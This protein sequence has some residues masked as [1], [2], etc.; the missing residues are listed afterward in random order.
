[1]AKKDASESD[2]RPIAFNIDYRY[3]SNHSFKYILR[4]FRYGRFT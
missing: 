1:M 3:A 2:I 4:E